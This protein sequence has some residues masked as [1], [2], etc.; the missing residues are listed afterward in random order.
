MSKFFGSRK[1][2]SGSEHITKENINES[3]SQESNQVD[4]KSLNEE[5]NHENSLEKKR[6]PLL[7]F[8][9]DFMETMPT[10]PWKKLDV[11][12]DCEE[13]YKFLLNSKAQ[14]EEKLENPEHN[15]ATVDDFCIIKTLGTGSFGRVM[16]VR[17]KLTQVYSAMKILEKKTIIKTKQVGHTIDERKILQAVNF[18]F[19]VKLEYHFKDN[20]NLYMV[21]EY[22]PGGEMFSHLRK[23]VKFSE[24]Q[25]RFYTAQ[26]VLA[27]EYL[28]HLDLIY[29]DLKPE[30]LLL[31]INGYIK[32][33]DFGFV[34]KLKSLGRTWTLCG[35]PEYLAPEIILSRG[36]NKSVDWWAL[37]IL[38]YEMTLGHPPFS[39]HEPIQIYE[40]ILI[41]KIHYPSIFSD[42]LKQL[43]K[44]LLAVDLTKRFG[45]MKNGV[46]DIKKASF[47]NKTNWKSIFNQTEV[48]PLLPAVS[49]PSDSSQYDRYDEDF[50]IFK[51]KPAMYE[52]EFDEF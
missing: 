12:L 52:E 46:D 50:D 36:Y 41:G 45:N 49:G 27:F 23:V 18:P 40:K 16:L 1:K 28:H 29:R 24:D 43:L 37:G 14:F 47:F 42:Q 15:T 20:S 38:L 48:A 21:L 11:K 22:V 9:S 5:S 34:K 4:N 44:N 19:L 39:A 35:T 33:T 30:N 31:D 7:D 3:F 13:H 32:I 10:L 2:N 17:N 8:V 6:N 51:T 25:A 26:I